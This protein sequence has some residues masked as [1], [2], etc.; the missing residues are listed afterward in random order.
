VRGADDL[1]RFVDR[2]TLCADSTRSRLPVEPNVFSD[3]QA[4]DRADEATPIL[5]VPA[6]GARQQVR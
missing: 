6:L 1:D 4:T 3:R 5:L 2:L